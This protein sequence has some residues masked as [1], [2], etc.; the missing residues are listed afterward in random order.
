MS[1]LITIE[2]MVGF[3]LNF[4]H[5]SNEKNK[6]NRKKFNFLET[7]YKNLNIFSITINKQYLVKFNFLY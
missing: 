6:S 1:V 3:L 5:R 4:R 7:T 2:G